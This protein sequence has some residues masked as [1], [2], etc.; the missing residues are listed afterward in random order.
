[1]SS[2]LDPEV[3]PSQA[4]EMIRTGKG[5]LAAFVAAAVLVVGGYLVWNKTTHI[6]LEL[7]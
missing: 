6:P 1:M 5:C 7:W 4:K 3:K 2:M